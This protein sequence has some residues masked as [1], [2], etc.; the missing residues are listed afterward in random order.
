[1]NLT[2]KKLII[3]K[4]VELKYSKTKIDKAGERMKGKHLISED[5]ESL[6]DVLS[7]WR[8]CHTMAS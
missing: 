6:L 8:S 7:N 1:M 4:T 2:S 5:I 3:M